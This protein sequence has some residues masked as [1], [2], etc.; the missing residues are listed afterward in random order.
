MTEKETGIS[1]RLRRLQEELKAGNTEALQL[2][3]KEVKEQGA[4][5]V[6]EIEGDDEY[7]L[8]T[9][10][11]QASGDLISVALVSLM[12]KPTTYLMTRMPG[13]DVWY[14]TLRLPSD[15]RATYQFFPNDLAIPPD[16]G[17]GSPWSYYHP[18]PLNPNTF[19]YYDEEEDPTGIKLTRSVLEL[20]Q[21]PAQPWIKTQKGVQK[22]KVH[23]AMSAACGYIPL[24]NIQPVWANRIRSWCCSMAGHMPN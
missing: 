6:E 3:W 14:A 20:P 13:T 17:S 22:G 4:P 18:D 7:C 24:R 1:P 2:F 23:L 5:L 12:T 15:L 16:E 19:A 21:A 11:W 8:V 10:L 9:F